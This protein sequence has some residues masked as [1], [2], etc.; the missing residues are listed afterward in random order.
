MNIYIYSILIS[1][2]SIISTSLVFLDIYSHSDTHEVITTIISLC[3]FIAIIVTIVVQCKNNRA[4]LQLSEEQNR[5][6]LF[7]TEIQNLLTLLYQKKQAIAIYRGRAFFNWSRTLINGNAAFI[8]IINNYLDIKMKRNNT[9]EALKCVN[10]DLGEIK[11]WVTTF[12]Y[13]VYRVEEYCNET[14][15]D[16][17]KYINLLK[18]NLNRNEKSFLQFSRFDHAYNEE[19]FLREGFELAERYGIIS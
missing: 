13:A 3:G 6:Q 9:Q 8:E 1:F 15:S 17:E 11:S 2:I 5:R 10:Y 7:E 4:Q 18:S 16:K 14:N 19:K 12:I